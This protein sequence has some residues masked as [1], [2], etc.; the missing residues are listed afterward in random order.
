MSVD[1]RLLRMCHASNSIGCL[2]FDSFEV[3]FEWPSGNFSENQKGL[4]RSIAGCCIV[5]RDFKVCSNNEQNS[6][7]QMSITELR[8]A[9]N[10]WYLW[11]QSDDFFSNKTL[12][13]LL[14]HYAKKEVPMSSQHQSATF[15]ASRALSSTS[16]VLLCEAAQTKPNKPTNLPTQ[17]QPKPNQKYQA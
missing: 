9:C 16:A 11:K 14:C 4:R 12:L 2:I 6:F 10:L 17:P 1:C 7:L 15:L 8:D 13:T 5:H 3:P